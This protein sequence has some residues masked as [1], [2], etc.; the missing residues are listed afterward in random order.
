MDRPMTTNV[1][2]TASP[3]PGE[4]SGPTAIY[5]TFGPVGVPNARDA[6]WYT[7]VVATDQ[8]ICLASGRTVGSLTMAAPV[9]PP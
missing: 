7:S 3:R 1:A 5:D 8:T 2:G 6:D 9:T 4:D